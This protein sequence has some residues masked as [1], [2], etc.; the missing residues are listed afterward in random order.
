MASLHAGHRLLV[1]CGGGTP[2]RRRLVWLLGGGVRGRLLRST[3]SHQCQYGLYLTGG[4][5]IHV[6]LL[7]EVVSTLYDVS[8]PLP[9][10]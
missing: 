9:L 7:A 5:V 4:L 8:M 6:V 2:C 3:S 10:W 1:E